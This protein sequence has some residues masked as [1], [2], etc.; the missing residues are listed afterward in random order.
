MTFELFLFYLF[1]AILLGAA[2]AMIS[3][4]NPVHAALFL[5][6]CFVS[7]AALWLMAEAEFL[8]LVL[9]LVYVGAVMVL[10]LF[11][12]MM[13]DINIARLREGFSEYLPVGLVVAAAMATVLVL[14]ITRYITMDAPERAG[15]EYANT[16]ALGAVLYTEYVYPFE[17]AAVILLVAII[18]A[19]SLTMRRRPDNKRIDPARQIEVSREGRVR[20]VSMKSEDKARRARGAERDD[21]PNQE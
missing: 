14:V 1:G 7:A 2:L 13:L 8:G 20:M 9:V 12:V 16:E 17:I 6:V 15:P 5:V 19:I 21:D 11:V 4:R 10:F 3:V 18:A